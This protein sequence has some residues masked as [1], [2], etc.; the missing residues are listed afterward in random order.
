M[1]QLNLALRL[2]AQGEFV[3]QHRYAGAFEGLSSAD[4]R[5]RAED[6]LS[7]MGYRLA[8]LDSNGAFFMAYAQPDQDT[9][10]RLR[11]ELGLL[12]DKLY[13]AVTF[14]ETIRQAQAGAGHLQAGDPV[15]ASEI[16]EAVRTSTVLERRLEQLK[17]LRGARL[18]EK[19]ADRVDRIL[20]WLKDDGY[21]YLT[22]EDLRIYTVTGKISYLYGLLAF[23]QDHTPLMNESEVDDALD[24]NKQMPL[25]AG[26]D[27]IAEA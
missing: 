27:G 26:A 19:S 14:L 6:W 25:G 11:D 3:C 21:L 24:D 13:P 8:Q 22:N 9:R 12:R 2:L 5:K 17:D 1:S 7:T 10:N 15:S 4:G 18:D 20:K 16:I 23:M